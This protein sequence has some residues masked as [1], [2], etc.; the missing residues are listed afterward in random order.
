MFLK[1]NMLLNKG[2]ARE[3]SS[4]FVKHRKQYFTLL[5]TLI[6]ILLLSLL[7]T[8]IFGFFRE[9]SLI[10]TWTEERE[11]ESFQMRYMETRLNYLFQ[12]LVNENQGTIRRF[13]FYTQP[14]DDHIS[15]APS[16]IFT[17]NNETRANPN[18]STDILARLY[19]DQQHRLALAMWPIYSDKPYQEMQKE[20]L[21]ENVA[22]INFGFYA[23]PERFSN[24]HPVNPMQPYPEKK[25]PEKN[26][27]HQEWFKTYS[28]MPSIL[29][30]EVHVATNSQALNK[31]A[32]KIETKILMF[33]FV[34]PSSQNYIFYSSEG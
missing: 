3:F 23:P 22:R 25:T 34:L 28:Q 33:A 11:K 14:P 27:W 13:Y 31:R 16:L 32:D 17:F 26:R 30:L 9:L 24:I 4:E 6:A 2:R 18:F 21:L 10:D 7:L 15:D 8:L 1:K 19:V 5:E 20:I 29:R 12:R